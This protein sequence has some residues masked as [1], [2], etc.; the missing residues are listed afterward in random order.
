LEQMK[1]L[2]VQSEGPNSM[3]DGH[4]RAKS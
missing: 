4:E 3:V 2:L 1:A